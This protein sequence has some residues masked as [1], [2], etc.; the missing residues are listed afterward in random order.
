MKKSSLPIL[1]LSF[2]RKIISTP[3]VRYRP[4]RSRPIR[5]PLQTLRNLLC[6]RHR[7]LTPRRKLQKSMRQLREMFPFNLVPRCLQFTRVLNANVSQR[8]KATCENRGR[9]LSAKLRN[10]LHAGTDVPMTRRDGL[11]RRNCWGSGEVVVCEGEDPVTF[12]VVPTVV[13]TS[14]GC[15]EWETGLRVQKEL[16][17]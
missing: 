13:L 4:N 14:S 16:T 3:V 11:F 5:H 10:V 8:V 17:R 2:A 7:L 15:I 12:E 9:R 6:R 1:D